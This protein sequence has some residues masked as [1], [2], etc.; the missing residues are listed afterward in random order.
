[1]PT[2]GNASFRDLTDTKYDR[3]VREA[4]RVPA[5]ANTSAPTF[6]PYDKILSSGVNASEEFE[7]IRLGADFFFPR[8]RV[9]YGTEDVRRAV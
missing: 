7:M 2:K 3:K 6:R 4:P 9:S 5:L 8:R 1:M